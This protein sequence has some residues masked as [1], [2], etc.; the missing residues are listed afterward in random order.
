MLRAAKCKGVQ[1]SCIAIG[2]VSWVILS[3]YF[4]S[5]FAFFYRAADNRGGSVKPPAIVSTSRQKK[6]KYI[7]R[8]TFFTVSA[9]VFSAY[10]PNIFANITSLPIDAAILTTVVPNSFSILPFYGFFLSL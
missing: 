9:A 2:V 10:F 5:K 4:A 8:G 3:A 6:R 1:T 7:D